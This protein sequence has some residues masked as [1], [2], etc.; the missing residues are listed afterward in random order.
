M[1]KEDRDGSEPRSQWARARH[2]LLQSVRVTAYAV[3]ALLITGGLSTIWH[4]AWTPVAVAA[5]WLAI[6]AVLVL[7]ALGV[8]RTRVWISRVSVAVVVVQLLLALLWTSGLGRSVQIY[9]PTGDVKWQFLGVTY[10]RS[11]QS[12]RAED[13][14]WEA[15]TSQPR[16]RA[17]WVDCPRDIS[18]GSVRWQLVLIAVWAE[19][20]P[21]IA[22]LMLDD[23]TDALQGGRLLIPPMSGLQARRDPEPA[24]LPYVAK[25]GWQQNRFI[26]GYLERHGYP[27]EDMEDAHRE[28][29]LQGSRRQAE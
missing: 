3:L 8:S 7:G 13:L 15:A 2:Y 5:V 6:A 4:P 21:A 11:Y 17:R 27:L 23:L 25:P 28:E 20:D 18:A 9:I 12:R 19:E 10:R 1:S 14:L 24:E 22:R 16:L 29:S 26:R